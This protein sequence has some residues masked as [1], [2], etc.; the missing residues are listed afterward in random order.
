MAKAG[1]GAD[2]YMIRFPP[3]LR[4]R[5]KA[6]AEHGGRSMNTE[7]VRTLEKE[8][9]EPWPLD[10]RIQHMLDLF[11]ALR[12]VQGHEAAISAMTSH[13]FDV[14]DSIAN[15]RVPEIDEETQRRVAERFSEWIQTRSEEE[16]DRAHW[17]ERHDE[18]GSK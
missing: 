2:Q 13:L 8:F 9:P 4:D 11:S 12:K 18:D 16:Q 5:I 7:I 10:A 17:Y 1:R 3:G 15:G 14:V 6:A